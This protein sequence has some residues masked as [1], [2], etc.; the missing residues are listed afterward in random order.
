M[1]DSILHPDHALI[2]SIEHLERRKLGLLLFLFGKRPP[3]DH[4][5]PGWLPDCPAP[6]KVA[7]LSNI[8]AAEQTNHSTRTAPLPGQGKYYLTI[9][10]RCDL[11][12]TGMLIFISAQNWVEQS[13]L[14]VLCVFGC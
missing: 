2:I 13:W 1:I 10:S 6:N 8:K 3:R 12:H 4:T 7:S 9:M 5:A 11:D 14:L